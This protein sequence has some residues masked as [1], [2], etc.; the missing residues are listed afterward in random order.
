MEYILKGLITS[1]LLESNEGICVYTYT[2]EER[3]ISEQLE[4]GKILSFLKI[5]IE[6]I[7][8]QEE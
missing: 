5:F 6:D 2:S 4:Q 8:K 7:L 1:M 3:S